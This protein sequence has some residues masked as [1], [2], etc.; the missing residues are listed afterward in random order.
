M[1][2]VVEQF[3]NTLADHV[4]LL[5]VVM[6]LVGAGLVRL[7]RHSGSEPVYFT[8]MVNVWLTFALALVMVVRFQPGQ[9]DVSDDSTRM[10]SSLNWLAEWK[11]TANAGQTTREAD[12][13]ESGTVHKWH[14][15]GPDVRFSVGVN[16]FSLWFMVLTVATTL[17]AFRCIP[18]DDTHLVS[19]LSWL[20]LTESA[21]LGTFAAQDLVLLVVCCQVSTLSLFF[22]IGQGSDPLRRE[23]ARRFFRVQTVSGMLILVGT[24]GVAISHWWMRSATGS[25]DANL[26]FS[27]RRIVTMV[28]RL[29]YESDAAH[30]LWLAVSPWLFVVLCGGLIL[31][32]PLPPFHHWWYR[33][34]E[35]ADCRVVAVMA[36]G[37]V[38]L[39]FYLMA[40]LIVPLFPE[41]MAEMAP[42]LFFWTLVAAVG[43]AASATAINGI[44]RRMAAIGVVSSTVALGAVFSGDEFGRLG[45][46]LLQLSSSGSLA[47]LYLSGS[48]SDRA[49]FTESADTTWLSGTMKRVVVLCGLAGLAVVPLSGSFWGEL[50]ILNA[51]F[52]RDSTAAFWLVMVAFLITLSVRQ[53]VTC[54]SGDSDQQGHDFVRHRTPHGGHPV[55]L[56]P[57]AVILI[58]AAVAPQWI[59]GPVRSARTD[60]VSRR[61]ESVRHW[62]T[63]ADLMQEPGGE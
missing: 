17:V 56:M 51:V 38:T 1:V 47:L 25:N 11:S 24:A 7:M 62:V 19:K 45:G 58:V 37:Y 26:S 6:P 12:T 52:R 59:I 21:M 44:R 50:L 31:R 32:L 54:R 60:D 55:H 23:A 2:N 30:D 10:T 53:C 34:C 3:W 16:R 8:G 61:A 4:V 46:L 28:P 42:R 57:V 14:P 29:A 48:V 49:I 41:L 13:Q 40:R 36:V 22:L 18:S 15:V 5:L 43:L 39:P 33:V 27:L 35:N 63:S 9:P 20:L